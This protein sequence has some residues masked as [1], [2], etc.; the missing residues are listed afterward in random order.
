MKSSP[1]VGREHDLAAVTA[2]LSSGGR[3]ARL[4]LLE[5]EAGIG[6]TSLADALASAAEAR[7]VEV[8]WGAGTGGDHVPPYWVWR[9]LVPPVVPDGDR[10][11]FVARLK[12]ALEGD[13][14]LVID[15]LQLVDE[16]S[17][18]ALAQLLRSRWVA[19]PAVLATRRTGDRDEAWQ[20]RVE[21]LLDGVDL[22]TWTVSGLGREAVPA[23]CEAMG[24]D[25][26]GTTIA[27]LYADSRGNPLVL[28]EL[29]VASV[30]GTTRTGR[31]TEL[32]RERVRGLSSRAQTLA[33][34]AAIVGD[35]FELTVT[36]RVCGRGVEASLAAADELLS[37]GIWRTLPARPGFLTFG[38]ALTRDAVLDGLSLQKRVALHRHAA[39]VLESLSADD[40]NRAAEIAGHWLAASVTGEREPV[41]RWSRIAAEQAL[42]AGAWEAA[43][44]LVSR[45][46]DQ[47]P[48]DH[49]RL[50]EVPLLTTRARARFLLGQHEDAAADARRA[51]RAALAAGRAE[52]ATAAALA[53]DPVGTRQWDSALATLLSQALA[54]LPPDADTLRARAHARWAQTA[55]YLKAYELADEH[56]SAAVA[57]AARSEDPEVLV[58]V[59][60]ARQ[61]TLSGPEH[62]A[63]RAEL[64]DQLIALGDRLARPDV[65]IWGHLWAVD[66]A[67]QHGDLTA[68][69][70]AVAQVERC[71]DRIDTAW[72]RWHLL[73]VKAAAHHARGRFDA[74]MDAAEQAFAITLAQGRP[75]IGALASLTQAVW[76]HRGPDATMLERLSDVDAVVGEVN[77]EHFAFVGTAMLLAYCGRLD[78]AGRLYRR[79]GDPRCWEIPPY[80]HLEL[81]Y[82]GATVALLLGERH[83]MGWFRAQL[84]P[85]RGQHV[86]ATAG[87]AAYDGPVALTLGRLTAA[88]GDLEAAERDLAEA[89][90]ATLA[91]GSTPYEIEASVSLAEVVARRGRPAEARTLV[92]AVRP[93]AV[94][95]GM[96]PWVSRIDDLCAGDRILSRR[97][98]EVARLVAVGFA[99]GDIARELVLSER[100]AENHVQH[101][102]TKLGFR[103]RS[104]IAAWVA[105]GQLQGRV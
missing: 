22:R 19:A 14:L 96:V 9:Q 26:T 1:L 45:A 55:V 2:L 11:E 5:G 53:L 4:V 59:L 54:A 60:H 32:V 64:A 72:A 48:A 99:N 24:V 100:T 66:V 102:L 98:A 50:S 105:S 56:S 58:D 92:R 73:L 97:E 87:T 33:S 47:G 28:R 103:N 61:L 95:L 30:S 20:A 29:M 7:G 43:T 6:K 57:A 71:S 36:A 63:T 86:T 83:D 79:A 94:R 78:G 21:P 101:I 84:E 70:R 40:P 34:A 80:F 8:R 18:S 17:V 104:Q 31:Y 27:N 69:D 68:L 82:A 51:H 39:R 42:E 38:H 90:A 15:D 23:L 93:R 16:S 67:A 37:A 12:D 91:N 89:V 65:E 81:L 35:P 44:R 10:F 85:W 49:V 52:L 75:V 46:L 77:G 62:V 74:A 13:G 76:N 3:R 25:L 88:L 41:L